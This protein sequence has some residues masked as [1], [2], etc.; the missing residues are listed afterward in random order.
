MRNAYLAICYA[1]NEG[2]RYCPCMKCERDDQSSLYTP[3]EKLIL[4]VDMFVQSGITDITISG[5]EPTLHPQ[6]VD[7]VMYIQEQK[8]DVTIL[9]NGERFS[10]TKFRRMFLNQ[11]DQSHLKYIT[12]IHSHIPAEHE[13]ANS[14][15]GSF[16]RTISGMQALETVGGRVIIKHCIT[17]RN[18]KDLSLFMPFIAA[19]FGSQVDVQFCSIDYCGIPRERMIAEELSFKELRPYLEQA[20]DSYEN[21][22]IRNKLYC[23]NIPLCSCD[24]Y[25]WKYLSKKRE[26]MYER[27]SDPTLRK[28]VVGY[29]NVDTPD[30]YCAN[31][32]VKEI[33]VGTYVTAFQYFGSEVISP[34]F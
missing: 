32:K 2:C 7:I 20:F 16:I 14:T 13:L 17:K 11:V 5:G 21:Q 22:R 19:N 28:I 6:L 18:Y 33:C 24:P 10:D 29:N 30:C 26:R 34:I 1:C 15:P 31:C 12:T 3:Y 4:K 8:I 25:Y 23:I 9:S 27:Y